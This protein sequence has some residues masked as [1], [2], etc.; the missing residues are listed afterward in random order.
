MSNYQALF[1]PAEE[2]GF[3]VTFPDFDWGVTQGDDEAEALEMAADALALMI[4]SDIRDG[5]LLPEPKQHRG[6]KFHSIELPA[7]QAAKAELY[8]QFTAGG[9]TKAELARRLG[10]HKTNVDRLFDLR[11]HS[12]L[13]HL[14]AACRAL[15]KKI[16]IE[17]QDADRPI[18]QKRLGKGTVTRNRLAKRT[19]KRLEPA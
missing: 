12:R 10:I 3:V 4:A 5:K 2:G 1:E 11:H 19:V 8:R 17:A 18:A 13:D 9:I 14:E 16:V 7:L 15:G 6:Q